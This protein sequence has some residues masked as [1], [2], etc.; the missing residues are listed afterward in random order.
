VRENLSD[1]KKSKCEKM[2]IFCREKNVGKFFSSSVQRAKKPW[3][4]RTG[5]R[6]F[7]QQGKRWSKLNLKE[8]EFWCLYSSRDPSSKL[9]PQLLFQN[10]IGIRNTKETKKDAKLQQREKKIQ[11]TNKLP[12]LNIHLSKA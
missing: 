12:K 8:H 10:S 11:I 3:E 4:T 5:K 7:Q 1:K 2:A 6:L 9:V